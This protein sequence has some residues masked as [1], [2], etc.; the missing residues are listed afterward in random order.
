M[1]HSALAKARANEI[2]KDVIGAAIDVHRELGPGLLETA[3]EACLEH[4]LK[5]RNFAVV[6]QLEL[7]VVYKGK[8]VDCA[9][10][11]DLLVEDTVLIELK[12]VER[13]DR[14]HEAQTITYLRL[15]NR[16]LGLLMNFNVTLLKNGIKRLV[17]SPDGEPD[18]GSI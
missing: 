9:Y 15:S 1:F 3:Y 5:S 8:P 6:R 7:P 13:L 18:T 11:I 16:W 12:S 14:I 10:R 2:S 17:W 4:E